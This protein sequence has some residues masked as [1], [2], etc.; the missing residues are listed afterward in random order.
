M[1]CPQCEICDQVFMMYC[2]IC[3]LKYSVWLWAI[4][5]ALN[6]RN[7]AHC[8]ERRDNCPGLQSV[9]CSNLSETIIFAG[10][11]QSCQYMW[12]YGGVHIPVH[13]GFLLHPSVCVCVCVCVCVYMILYV[14]MKSVVIQLQYVRS[15]ADI[16][17]L[18]SSVTAILALLMG[19][20]WE[21]L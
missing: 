7:A 13:Y 2:F 10:I 5:T 6:Y 18:Q 11:L 20:N 14:S 8:R 16:K 19:T 3:I 4:L 9:D 21:V 15:G 12:I 1:Q 17:A